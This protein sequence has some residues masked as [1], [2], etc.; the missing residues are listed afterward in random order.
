MK[1]ESFDKFTGLQQDVFQNKQEFPSAGS[2]LLRGQYFS[3]GAPSKTFEAT[4][5]RER[6]WLQLKVA[7][8]DNIYNI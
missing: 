2:F 3:N 6:S 8:L 7:I 4:S 5:L 1:K